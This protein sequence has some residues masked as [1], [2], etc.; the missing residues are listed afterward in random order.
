MPSTGGTSFLLTIVTVVMVLAVMCQCPQRAGPHFYTKKKEECI[1]KKNV[2]MPSTGGT[3]FLLRRREMKK[4]NIFMCQCPQRAGPHFYW[5]PQKS[6][7]SFWVCQCP[8][9]AGPHF[10]W[11]ELKEISI[12]HA[13]VN[14]LNGRDLIS[15]SLWTK[16]TKFMMMCQC[17]QRAGPHFYAMI[18]KY[19]SESYI[20]SMPSTGG[21]SFL[22][23]VTRLV[24]YAD[25]HV[26]MPSTGG[27]SF[28]RLS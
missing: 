16:W 21:T 23:F 18:K 28:L 12:S 1:M 13:G 24:V 25:D 7:G 10:Y 9:R 15:T 11:V 2:S 4:D 3:S 5:K 22:P 8:Q 19:C 17:P 6:P 14:A 20:V 27:T 26:S